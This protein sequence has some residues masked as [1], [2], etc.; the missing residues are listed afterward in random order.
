MRNLLV[1]LAINAAA[2][3]VAGRYVTGVELDGELVNVAL[4]ALIFGLVNALIKPIIKL[5]SLP[6]IFLTLGLVTIVI[7]GLMLMLTAQLTPYLSVTGLGPA[8]VGSLVISLVSFLLNT[9]L[10]DEKRRD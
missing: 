4:V 6:L 10:R 2:L 8:V 5:V 9:F 1:R 7:N 3:W